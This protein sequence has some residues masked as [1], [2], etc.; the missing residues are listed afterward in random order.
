MTVADIGAGTGLL[1]GLFAKRVGP[2]GKV[3]AVDIVP[4]FLEHIRTR[5]AEE[6]ITNVETLLCTEDS[7]ELPADSIDVA[8]IC[9]TYHHF[10]FPH[11]TMTS[12]YQA[13]KP[14]GIVTI[15]DFERIPDVSRAWILQHVRAGK[16]TFIKEI[17][18]AGFE[19]IQD[20]RSHSFLKE[21]YVIRFRRPL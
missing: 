21:N 3:Y 2:E 1:T 11:S 20:G 19:L 10:E 16:E 7:V 13:M 12:L 15:V 5:V 6:N 8:L 9:D 4:E 14:G 17:E 18:A